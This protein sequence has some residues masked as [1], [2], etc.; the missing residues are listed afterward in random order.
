MKKTITVLMVVGALCAQ[1]Q[2]FSRNRVEPVIGS[3]IVGEY[4]WAYR[5]NGDAVEIVNRGSVA[6]SPKPKGV[7][8][9]PSTL[10]GKPVTS[11][12]DRAFAGCSWI[13]RVTI[14]DGVTSIDGYAFSG[15][16]ALTSIVMPNVTNIGERAFYN[17]GGLASVTMPK[18][19]S[20]GSESFRGCSGLTSVVMQNVTS[21][22]GNAFSGC[23]KLT[24]MTMPN[25]IQR[26]SMLRSDI[27]D[28]ADRGLRRTA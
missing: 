2:R 24:S 9:V 19:I 14:P 27:E 5:I 15:C 8:T 18:V 25:A 20:I 3:E 7:I 26:R 21:V 10:S 1:A 23:H 4:T 28:H 13:K 12:G 16:S 17:C 6:I 11:I 22:G